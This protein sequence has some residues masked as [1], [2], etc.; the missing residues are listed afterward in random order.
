MDGLPGMRRGV[1]T[2]KREDVKPIKKMVGPYGE[3]VN[4]MRV[5][6]ANT[7]PVWYLIIVALLSF[8]FGIIAMALA[9]SKL[10][11]LGI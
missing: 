7:V 4:Q 3:M 2:A 1:E 5:Q 11:S 6:R 10:R 9:P 8:S